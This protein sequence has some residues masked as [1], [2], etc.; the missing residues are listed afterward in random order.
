M[1]VATTVT[2]TVRSSDVIPPRAAW[3][4]VVRAA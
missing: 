3:S 2:G 4:A 1:T